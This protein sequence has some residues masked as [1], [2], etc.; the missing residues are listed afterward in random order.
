MEALL[1]HPGPFTLEYRQRLRLWRVMFKG[2]SIEALLRELR[3]TARYWC[4]MLNLVY[5][6]GRSDERDNLASGQPT[7]G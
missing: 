3:E 6:W 1:T 4:G 5:A 2:E 7:E